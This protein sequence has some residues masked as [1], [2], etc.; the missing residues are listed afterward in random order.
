M[1]LIH[2]SQGDATFTVAHDELDAHI[3]S[4]TLNIVNDEYDDT[5]F[6]LAIEGRS[7]Y[8]GMYTATGT[9]QGFLDSVTLPAATAYAAEKIVGT[10]TLTASTGRTYAF[11]AFPNN[12]QLTVNKQTGL[13]AISFDFK[14]SGTISFA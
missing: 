2:G 6:S 10:L 11:S 14:S 1:A 7:A 12:I 5:D 9:C 3:V 13:N 4:F 8:M